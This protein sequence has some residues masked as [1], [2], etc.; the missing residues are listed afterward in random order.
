MTAKAEQ[1]N[2]HDNKQDDVCSKCDDHCHFGGPDV[3]WLAGGAGS[4]TCVA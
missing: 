1:A 3:K 2:K 4:I